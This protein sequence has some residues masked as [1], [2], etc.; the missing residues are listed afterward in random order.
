M[1]TTNTQSLDFKVN[2]QGKNK[3]FQTQLKTIFE[4][5]KNNTATASMVAEA[6]G[7]PQKSICRYKRDL[8]KQGLLYEVEKR[9]CKLTGFRAYYLTTNQDKMP[10][11]NQT[12]LF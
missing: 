10:K 3:L 5:L 11:S 7:V 8:E 12:K 1:S 6:T 4:Y 2:E 9:H